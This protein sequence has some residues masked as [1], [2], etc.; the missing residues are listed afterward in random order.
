MSVAASP[1]TSQPIIVGRDAE[2]QR[3]AACLKQAL[4]GCGRLVLV[5]GEAG[6]GKTTL[7]RDLARGAAERGALVLS[8]HCYDLSTTPPYG[9]WVEVIRESPR[10]DGLPSLS[11]IL[12]GVDDDDSPGRG[13]ELFAWGLELFSK[14]AASQ[15][16]LIVMED[17]HWADRASL[18][19]LRFLGRS[20][21]DIPVLIVAT[22]RA[23]EIAPGHALYTLL[24][25][26]IRESQPERIDLQPLDESA[27]TEWIGHAYSLS[28]ADRQRLTTYLQHHAEGNPFFAGE[29]LR[30]LETSGVLR[31]EDDSWELGDLG[32]VGVPVLLRQVLE[33][34]IGRVSLGAREALGLAS[35]I[36]QYVDIELWKELTGL[37]DTGALDIAAEASS[38]SLIDLSS[39]GR[40]FSFRHALIREALYE[41]ILPPRRR[42]LHKQIAEALL[43][44]NDPDPDTVAH[45]LQEAGDSRAGEWLIKAGDRAYYRAYSLQTAVARYQSAL[46][47]LTE[48]ALDER[49]WLLVQLAQTVRYLD[50]RAGVRYADEA[51]Q[52]ALKR[53]DR[54]LHAVALRNRGIL[55]VYAGENALNDLLNGY[56]QID[57]LTYAE[58]CVLRGKRQG[59]R[60]DTDLGRQQMALWYATLG[61]YEEAMETSRRAFAMMDTDSPAS[62]SHAAIL[63]WGAGLTYASLGDPVRATRAFQQSRDVFQIMKHDFHSGNV[64]AYEFLYVVLMYYADNTD[65]VADKA[66][67]VL[68]FGEDELSNVTSDPS[69]VFLCPLYLIDGRWTELD[70]IDRETRHQPRSVFF[71]FAAQIVLAEYHRYIGRHDL[72]LKYVQEF[73]PL[74]SHVDPKEIQ[75]RFAEALELQRVAADLA[76]DVRSV[77][78]ARDWIDSRQQWMN[79]SGRIAGQSEQAI[80][81][82]RYALLTGEIEKSGNHAREAVSLAENP[83][84]PL[85]LLRAHRIHGKT[86]TLLAK[87]E[88]AEDSFRRAMDLADMC[89]APYERALVQLVLAQLHHETDNVEEARSELAAARSV[90]ER[91]NAVPALKQLRTLQKQM[92]T[93]AGHTE[94][95]TAGL[96]ER[97]IE[98]LHLVAEGLTDRLIGEQLFISPRTVSQHMRSIFNKIGVNSRTAAAI[99][100]TELGI[101][102]RIDT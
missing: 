75:F 3:L 52:I 7:V 101:L 37:S 17:M 54:A 76:L 12:S 57:Q 97:E 43:A 74:G 16:E 49:G 61:R 34:R 56:D 24:P 58:T 30:E 10:V 15:P 29:I 66:L 36:G 35:I 100:A 71:L 78:E 84:Q 9:P 89:K 41:E 6:I 27:I 80:L 28:T 67:E 83:R 91:L 62:G 20:V 31:V 51:V 2:R 21:S 11:E 45:H 87:Y 32:D 59:E 40:Q 63:H 95:D 14:L 102:R 73:L 70:R 92:E 4:D 96:S 99:K 13:D 85:S 55:R 88:Q 81:E 69:D 42:I 5:S 94:R 53:G 18:D 39:D 47:T 79:L 1:P 38:V 64:A 50:P 25:A 65:L 48:D 33:T 68:E 82:A 90:F 77:S 98:V 23:D 72:A 8:G 86:L 44:D 60:I 26:M 22:Y 93:T 46:D 19:F